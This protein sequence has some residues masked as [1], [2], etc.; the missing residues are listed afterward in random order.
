MA[1]CV[2]KVQG[3]TNTVL[4]GVHVLALPSW[5]AL[6]VLAIDSNGTQL[7]AATTKSSRG[8]W[9]PGFRPIFS[10]LVGTKLLR[11]PILAAQYFIFLPFFRPILRQSAGHRIQNIGTLQLC[12]FWLVESYER[13]RL[14]N[15]FAAEI[16]PGAS[17]KLYR[18]CPVLRSV[19]VQKAIGVFKKTRACLRPAPP[20]SPPP[21][22]G[23]RVPSVPHLVTRIGLPSEPNSG[24]ATTLG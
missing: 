3:T 21:P 9:W 24:V 13:V 15:R 6:G 16:H 14:S 22:P 7:N 23:A 10:V 8:V 2:I 5:C 17:K 12:A 1:C 20:A 11:A 18:R 4:Q 19:M